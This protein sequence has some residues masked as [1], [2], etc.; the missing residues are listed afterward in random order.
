[1]YKKRMNYFLVLCLLGAC[2]SPAVQGEEMP[3]SFSQPNQKVI[4]NENRSDVEES[5]SQSLQEREDKQ[6][7]TKESLTEQE[8]E[9]NSEED[10]ESLPLDKPTITYRA[11]QVKTGWSE[12][13]SFG[14]VMGDPY[15]GQAL[16]GIQLV[17]QSSEA[18]ENVT[19]QVYSGKTGWQPSVSLGQIAGQTQSQQPIEG[20]RF[21]LTGSLASHYDMYYRVYVQQLGWLSWATAEEAAGT[22][23]YGYPV[24]GLEAQLVEKNQPAPGDTS[25]PFKENDQVQLTYQTYQVKQGWQN[26][27]NNG[28]ISGST[29]KSLPLSGLK[30]QLIS[31]KWKGSITYQGHF[32]N[33][34]WQGITHEGEISG[35][36]QANHQLEGLRVNLTEELA[37]QYDVYYQVHVANLGW[38]GWAKNGE[39][40]GTTGFAYPIEGLKVQLVEKDQPAPGSVDRPFISYQPLTVFYQ[41]HVSNQGWLLEASAKEVAGS[42]SERLEGIKLRLNQHEQLTGG[43]QYQAHSQ[44]IGWQPWVNDSQLAGTVGKN[45]RLEAIKIRLTGE[46]ATP[47]QVYYRVYQKRLGGWQAWCQNSEQAG[48]VGKGLPI[49]KI[50]V[51]VGKNG[52]HPRNDSPVIPDVPEKPTTPDLENPSLSAKM[53]QV[54][55]LLTKE[56]QHQSIGIYV[57]SINHPNIVAKINEHQQFMPSSLGRLPIIYW[58]D[59]QLKTKKI[60]PTQKYLYTDK[61]N[62]FPYAYQKDGTGMLQTKPKGR[63]YTVQEVLN[64]TVTTSDN[65]GTNFLAYH[66]GNQYDQAFRQEMSRVV[67]H[68]WTTPFKASAKDASQVMTGLYHQNGGAF[69]LYQGVQKNRG[70][71][72]QMSAPVYHQLGIYQN[73]Y[74][75]VGIVFSDEPYVLAVM[76]QQAKGEQT[77][78]KLSKEVYQRLK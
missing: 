37:N 59:Q 45:K 16:T 38:L 10:K 13:T 42:Q 66:V 27:V 44:D 7:Q 35:T 50:Q 71:A 2:F 51:Y 73:Y 19:Y 1:M 47:Y 76:S 62:Q 34:G 52:Q 68:S 4:S 72:S 75:D 70:I 18:K 64:W 14:E 26:K 15:Q 21:Q 40:A 60:A 11:Y 17:S 78:A 41:P 36:L 69:D 55:Q 54:Q 22:S 74:H 48:T 32:S 39:S 30:M 25:L 9:E 12:F 56:Y 6:Q 28:F 43:I 65:E 46:I 3:S 58:T 5:A 53:K 77:V 29:G 57:A 63:N 31:P 8:P 20:V 24:L 67:G 49:E 61:V 23:G 33:L